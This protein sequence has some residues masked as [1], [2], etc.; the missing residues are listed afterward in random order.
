MQVLHD[1]DTRHFVQIL[2]GVHDQLVQI[3]LDGLQLEFLSQS[4]EAIDVNVNSV[5]GV[6]DSAQSVLAKLRIVEMEG[7]ILQGQAKTLRW[8]S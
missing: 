4:A 6:F 2:Q 1:L 5:E 7:K 8:S 3:R